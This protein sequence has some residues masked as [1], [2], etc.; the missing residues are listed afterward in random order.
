VLC[1]NGF[2]V[3]ITVAGRTDRP[4]VLLPGAG[5]GRLALEIASKGY[6]V[7]GNEFSYQ[8]LFAS[9]F[10]LNWWASHLGLGLPQACR[11]T[12]FLRSTGA[13]RVSRP[14]EFEIHPWIHNP[15][16]ALTI[17]DLL[18]PVAVPDVAPAELLGLNSGAVLQPDFSMCAGEFLEA[19]ASDKGELGMLQ[20]RFARGPWW[21]TRSAL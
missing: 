8:M 2:A 4:R 12:V 9:N 3:L 16:N 7:Q 20:L 17:T 13:N 18:R 14:L 15:S 1:W 19:Y 21:L 6:A 11:L 5:L 10:I